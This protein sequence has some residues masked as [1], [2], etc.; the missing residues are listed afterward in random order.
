MKYLPAYEKFKIAKRDFVLL[1]LCAVVHLKIECIS[2]SN[3]S[4]MRIGK[5]LEDF[6]Y[7]IGSC[8]ERVGHGIKKQMVLTDKCSNNPIRQIFIAFPLTPLVPVVN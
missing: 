7:M 3:T 8:F 4:T 5:P 1:L 2:Y 6:D